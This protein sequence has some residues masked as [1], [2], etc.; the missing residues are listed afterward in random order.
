M[1]DQNQNL[2]EDI[3]GF[4]KRYQNPTDYVH[5]AVRNKSDIMESPFIRQPAPLIKKGYGR[6]DSNPNALKNLLY[7][8]N[9]RVANT[10][11]RRSNYDREYYQ[12]TP[13]YGE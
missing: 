9:K 12:G 7:I 11:V 2:G 10:N 5:R 1:N 8:D 6:H 4:A 13:P 3:Y